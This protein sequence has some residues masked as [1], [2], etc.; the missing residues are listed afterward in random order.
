MMMVRDNR[1]VDVKED[2]RGL[3]AK[4]CLFATITLTDRTLN[5]FSLC[6]FSPT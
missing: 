4:M 1:G 5:L 6:G 3:K 2:E